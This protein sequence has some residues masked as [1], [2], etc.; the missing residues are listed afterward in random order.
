MFQMMKEPMLTIKNAITDVVG[1]IKKTLMK[2][3][4][5]LVRVKE[6]LT[7]IGNWQRIF[8]YIYLNYLQTP[9]RNIKKAFNFLGKIMYMCNKKMG[10]PFQRCIDA[11][12]RGSADCRFVSIKFCVKFL[13]FYPNFDFLMHF[14]FIRNALGPMDIICKVTDLVQ[15]ICFNL[16]ILDL[17]CGLVDFVSDAIVDVVVKRL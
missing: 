8:T 7:K 14:C 4:K 5:M 9:V 12:E 13:D 2:V 3:R 10:S 1:K 16:K 11:L 17:M 6:L 15:P